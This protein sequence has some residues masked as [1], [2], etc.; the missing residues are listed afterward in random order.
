MVSSIN[1]NAVFS[2]AMLSRS[3]GPRDAQALQEKLFT[4]LD[5]NGDGGIDKTELSDFMSFAA[6]SSGTQATDGAALFSSIDSDGDGAITQTELSDGAK[7]LF[8]ELRAQL[9]TSGQE[10]SEAKAV[11]KP[12]VEDLFATIDA[13]G[14]GSIDQDELGTFMSTNPPP[15]PG[16]SG[17]HG[18]GLFSRIESLLDQYR[19]TA[20]TETETASG[21]SVAA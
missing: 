7:A 14:D 13:N 6:Q 18:G 15:P 8:D 12:N 20:T 3:Q 19:S 10:T 9:M 17:G 5:S 21:L 16:G 11:E 4:K 2:S 1:S